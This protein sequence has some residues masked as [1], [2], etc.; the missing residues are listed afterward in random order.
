MT[1]ALVSEHASPLATLGGVDAGGQNVHVA[2]LADALARRGHRVTVYTRRDDPSLPRRVAFT[3]GVEVV[4][5]DAGPAAPV[6]KDE[7]L[8]F[9]GDFAVDLAQDWQRERPDLVHSHFWMSGVAALDASD[10]VERATGDRVPVFHTFHALGVV[11]RRQ[12]GALDT[13]PEERAWLEPG[14]G[15]RVDGVIATC[16]D[17]AFELK[18]LG[19]PTARISVVPCGVDIDRFTVD[20]PVAPRGERRRLMTIGRLV[21]RKGMGI[22][23]EALS[24][25]VAAGVDA[26]LVIVGGSGSGD[27][28]TADPEYQRLHAVAESLGV[29][30]RVDFV[31]QLSQNEMPAMLRSAEVVVCAPWYEPFG[32][33]P[34][35]AMACGVPVVA[36][37]VGGLIDTVVEDVTGVHVPPRD[38]AALA[39]ALTALLTD[40]ERA[41]AYGAAGRDRVESRYSWER[42][43]ADT[44]R[45]YTA[46]LAA[47][48]EDRPLLT[49]TPSSPSS[50]KAAPRR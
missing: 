46:T 30:D 45:A 27:A 14:V 44:E 41:R 15:Q 18:G 2:A 11:K 49:G 38:P 6:P 35:E 21:P 4:H 32:I 24:G 33:T 26:E 50:R 13:S 31:G 1:I 42:V 20:G 34:L 40:P 10:R 36:T 16:S 7:L 22:S 3:S 12:Q 23:I 39:A 43:A 37:S 17:E 9:M 8:P 19:V 5:V 47:L 29:A 25:V 28:L 48:G